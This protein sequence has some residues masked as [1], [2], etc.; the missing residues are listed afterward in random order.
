MSK[1]RCQECGDIFDP[2]DATGGF[3]C[4][5]PEPEV[6]I[7]ES[8]LEA[9]EAAEAQIER[10]KEVAI[11]LRIAQR[12]DRE[13]CVAIVVGD[14]ATML[15]SKGGHSLLSRRD[16]GEIERRLNAA[17]PNAATQEPDP[18]SARRM[19]NLEALEAIILAD[20]DRIRQRHISEDSL[21]VLARWMQDR[22][23]P[24]PAP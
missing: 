5:P 7:E 3:H 1:V 4:L 18:A 2:E 8:R 6:L 23:E 21:S 13:P 9:L 16:V 17:F 14:G 22:Q 11:I 19:R 10:L 12:D 24:D 20:A 15:V